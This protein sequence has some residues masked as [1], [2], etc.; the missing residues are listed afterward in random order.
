MLVLLPAGD[1]GVISLSALQPTSQDPT[2]FYF[3]LLSNISLLFNRMTIEQ[4]NYYI[5]QVI[6]FPM[7]Y[8]YPRII[9]TYEKWILIA[10]IL[11]FMPFHA[12]L[13]KLILYDSFCQ[14]H[15]HMHEAK[16]GKRQGE[17]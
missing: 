3:L 11:I 1:T 9:I 17:N 4:A 10:V 15:S 5:L 12:L 6:I 16:V 14:K 2:S 8:R 7:Q 13:I